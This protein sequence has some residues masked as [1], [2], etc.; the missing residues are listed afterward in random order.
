MVGRALSAKLASLGHDVLVGTRDV[1]RTEAHTEPDAW[2]NPPFRTWL[3]QNPSVRLGTFAAAAAHGEMVVNATAGSASLG[4]LRSASEEHLADKILVD[5]A[6]PLDFSTGTLT[7][8]VCNTD[9]LGEQIQRTFPRARVVKTLNTVNAAVMVEPAQVANGDHHLFVSGNDAEAKARVTELLTT[10]F[11]WRHVVDL[12]D[13]TTA[14]GT[15]ALLLLWIS[16]AGVSGTSMFNF[17]IAQ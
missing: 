15:E 12:G 10:G 8:L 7:L 17:K 4:A 6:N 13:I 3:A 9:S 2:G 11:G 16:L 5:V 14:R 1:A